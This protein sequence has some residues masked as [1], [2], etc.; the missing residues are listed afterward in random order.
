M[1]P[2]DLWFE[3]RLSPVEFAKAIPLECAT[4]I[5]LG[6]DN[7]SIIGDFA[8]ATLELERNRDEATNRFEMRIGR[9]ESREEFDEPL[10]IEVANALQQAGAENI[11]IGDQRCSNQKGVFRY[12]YRK[13]QMT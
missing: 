7:W 13:F 11:H 4:V 5:D 12:N 8:G 2:T 3:S 1:N 9:Y 10:L 6:A